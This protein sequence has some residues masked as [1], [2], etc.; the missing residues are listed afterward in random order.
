MGKPFQRVLA[1]LLV[2]LV[3]PQLLSAQSKTEQKDSLVRLMKATS[4]QLVEEYGK[5]Y[6]KTFDATFLHNGTYLICD[7]A[8]WDVERKVINAFGH[9]QVIQDE[10][11]L[12]SEKL[13]Y[14]IDDDLAQFR[15]GV[16]Q[17]QNKKLN[18]LRTHILDYNTKDSTAVFTGGASMKDEDG[19]IIESIDGTYNSSQKVFTFSKDVNMFTDSVFVRTQLLEYDSDGSRANFLSPIDF[20]KEDKMLS[21]DGGWYDRGKELF[22]FTGN[23]H[24]LGQTQEVW[25]DSL[26]YHKEISELEMFGNAQIQ[27]TVRNSAALAGYIIYQDTLSKVTL[28]REAAV[29]IFSEAEN[30]RD[31]LYVGADRLI[32]R[33]IKRNEIP[34]AVILE[35]TKRL[36]SMMLDPVS[37]YREKAAQEAAQAAQAA[38]AEAIKTDPSVAAKAKAE[39]LK[40]G[41]AGLSAAAVQKTEAPAEVP[42]SAAEESTEESGE[43][44]EEI[45][46]FEEP[47][48]DST[49]I[50]FVNAIGS[51]KIFRSD[52]QAACDSLVYCD[53]DSI[54]RL[55]VDPKVWNEGNRQY[56]SDSLFVLV[57]N[58]GIER[59]SLQSNAFIMIQEDSTAFD[60]I[61]GAEVM[62]YFD[63]T[64]ALRRFDALGGASAMFYLQEEDA[65]ATVNVVQCKMLSATLSNGEVER[66]Y[67]F[68]EPK[69]DAYPRAQL[70]KSD[71]RLSGFNWQPELRPRRKTDITT[72]TLRTTERAKYEARPHSTFKQTDRYFP[73][74]M[75][76]V[77]RSIEIRDSLK[78]FA[79]AAPAVVPAPDTTTIE[80]VGF[81][82]DTTSVETVTVPEAVDATVDSLGMSSPVDS[83]GIMAPADSL[84]MPVPADSLG[85]VAPSD[86]SQLAV[87]ADTLIAHIPTAAE[88]KKAAR[89]AKRAERDSI[90]AAKQAVR[91][92][93]EAV[94]V[95]AQEAR[96]ARLDSL[97]AIKQAA[98]DQKK[99]EKK[100]AATRRSLRLKARQD[101]REQ[102][103]LEK[104]IRRYERKKARQ[105]RKRSR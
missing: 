7:T 12:T 66:V 56:I 50:G 27:D 49:K 25:S 3:A 105:E 46:E 75:A 60:Q 10:T 63:T 17:L 13:D 35:S 92:S 61:K 58:G 19:Q 70:K 80:P 2:A 24:G 89:A 29:A 48:V 38:L 84:V 93:L 86:S 33:T 40:A 8:L 15:G 28:S 81:V 42:E 30:G 71:S 76:S 47:A 4:V 23:V 52:L 44:S 91:D 31:T 22:F 37:E 20:W 78:K 85:M 5:N 18:T 96:W 83:L 82:S 74:Y 45:E 39:A 90:A 9:V 1:I 21:A 95:A 68:Q 59:A 43:G 88:L 32:Y 51:V 62:A 55:F 36:E 54:A 100:R 34:D 65:L 11:I 102:K 79:P 99:L 67:Y 16:V 77:Y 26:Y 64:S 98:K 94:R 6:R 73:G 53:L 104:Y 97:D 103:Y 87:S 41:K 72:L 14:Y 57:K 101:R 69:N